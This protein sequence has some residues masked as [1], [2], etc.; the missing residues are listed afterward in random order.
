MA[1]TTTANIKKISHSDRA[2]DA[3][4]VGRTFV[5]HSLKGKSNSHHTQYCKRRFIFD[6]ASAGLYFRAVSNQ[7]SDWPFVESGCILQG[8]AL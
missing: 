6:G 1:G 7:L 4:V 2:D 3:E 5:A 8:E